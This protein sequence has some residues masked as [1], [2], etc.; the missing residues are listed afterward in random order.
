M[1]AAEADPRESPFES[2]VEGDVGAVAHGESAPADDAEL[3]L[4]DADAPP[5]DALPESSSACA[6]PEPVARAAPTPRVIAPAP[7]HA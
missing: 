7:S 5:D 3:L 1:P 4:A 2:S 6:T